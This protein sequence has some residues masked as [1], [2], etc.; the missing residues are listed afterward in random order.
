MGSSKEGCKQ[1]S[2]YA[3]KLLTLRPSLPMNL[4]VGIRSVGSRRGG[5]IKGFRF[6]GSGFGLYAGVPDSGVLDAMHHFLRQ[7]TRL[8]LDMI[9][10]ALHS[11]TGLLRA[12]LRRGI[13]NYRGSLQETMIIE[14][15]KA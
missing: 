1:G 7:S 4:Q 6:R 5:L 13:F 8:S 9:N 11:S 10:V 14:T 12:E 2:L 15:P 3:R